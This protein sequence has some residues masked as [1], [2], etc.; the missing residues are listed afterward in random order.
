MSDRRVA[1]RFRVPGEAA[2]ERADRVIARA[3][4]HLGR[5]PIAELFAR[6]AVRIDGHLAKKGERVAAGAL[7]ELTDVPPEPAAAAPVPATDIQLEPLILYCDEDLIILAK[8]GGMPSHPL[9][10]E[11]DRTLANALMARFPEC[12][13]AGRDAREAG[14][15]HRLDTGT[16]GVLAAA[17]NARAWHALRQAFSQGRVH[18]RYWALIERA[19]VDDGACD[20]PLVRRGAH[21]RVARPG[22]ARALS[23]HTSWR[24]L[25]RFPGPDR[26]LLECAAR[27][28]RPHQVRVHLAHALA[29]IVGDSQYG[30]HPSEPAF[31]GFFLHARALS[32][33]H[34]VTGALLTV[35]APLPRDRQQL[36]DHLG[37]CDLAAAPR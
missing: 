25:A 4:P 1:L 13:H 8:P 29:P 3:L 9:R 20:E 6:G 26:A 16:S 10:P 37:G 15:V 18:K 36:L 12:A 21:V 22:D 5:R 35:E 17:R 14:L 31:T 24:V 30:G 34:P 19:D 2:P 7:V 27:T 11:H 28:G 32:L 23:A 33:P